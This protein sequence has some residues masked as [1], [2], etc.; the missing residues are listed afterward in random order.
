MRAALGLQRATSLQA[1][2]VPTVNEIL[3]MATAG[4]AKLLDMSDHIGSLTPGK[5]ADLIVIDPGAVN[6]APKFEAIPQIVFN[7]QTQN[8]EWVFVDG[9]VLKRK[10][11]LVGVNPDAVMKD[12]QK[13]ADRIHQ[14]LFP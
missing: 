3:R 7:A 8:V 14:F 9:R 5:K 2:I 4:G 11:K 10:G 12:A 13:V 1:N 6:F